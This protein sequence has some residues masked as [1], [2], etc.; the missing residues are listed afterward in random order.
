MYVYPK[1]LEE[2]LSI[3]GEKGTAVLSGN[4]IKTW[5]FE[6]MKEYNTLEFDEDNLGHTPLYKD[7][8][9]LLIIIESPSYGEEEKQ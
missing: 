6:D 9:V 1:N 8:I 7:F 2:T 3:F 4:K 5:Q